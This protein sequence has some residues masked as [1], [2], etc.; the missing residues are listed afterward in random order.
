MSWF[1]IAWV[2]TLCL[3]VT[4]LILSVAA[5]DADEAARSTRLQVACAVVVLFMA[6]WTL[7]RRRNPYKDAFRFERF[8]TANG[9]DY[10]A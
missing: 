4:T 6:V 7:A 2:A 9:F 3:A 10:C 8:A 1:E 5:D